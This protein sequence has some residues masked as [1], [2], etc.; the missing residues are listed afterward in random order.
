VGDDAVEDVGLEVGTLNDIVTVTKGQ[1]YNIL[2][3]IDVE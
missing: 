1:G 2:L 3:L